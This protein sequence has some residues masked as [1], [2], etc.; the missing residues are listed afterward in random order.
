MGEMVS[1]VDGWIELVVDENRF[2]CE[3]SRMSNVPTSVRQIT[4]EWLHNVMGLGNYGMKGMGFSEMTGHNPEL[5]QLF[6]IQVTYHSRTDEHP[7]SIV[8]KIPPEDETVRVREAAFGP[9]V[10]ELGCYRLLE[11]FWGGPIARMYGAAE[12]PDE[13]TV[14]FIFEDLGE[15]PDGQKYAKVD[16]DVAKSTLEFM[17]T[18]HARYWND[19]ELGRQP[20]IRDADWSFLFNQ[21]PLNSAIGWQVIND[22]DRFEKTGGLVV[23]G[24]Y[25]G[26]RLN[27]LRDAMRSRPNTLTHN[28]FH[29]GNVLL[30][31]TPE[32]TQ[33]V[34]IDWQMPAFAGGTND[35]AKFMMTAVPF[36]ILAEQESALVAYYLDTLKANGVVD[37]SFDECWRD[38][39]RAQVATFGNYAISCY[40]TSP[41]GGL[42]A[43]SGDSTHAVIRALTLADPVEL[44]AFLP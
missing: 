16:L 31:Q 1:E 39:R 7:D 36:D 41:D 9:Y 37:Y 8:V 21:N 12:N 3:T 25:L 38:Y 13:K 22:D 40:E 15:L 20:W 32:G 19:D 42:V 34:I 28:D 11:E 5:S 29:Q 23:A 4:F 14:A 24:E 18:F 26:T 6:R 44:K 17:A 10:S 2:E 30:R 33:P 27:D 43:S 35:L